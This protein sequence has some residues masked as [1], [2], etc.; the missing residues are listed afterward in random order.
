MEDTVWKYPH[1][2]EMTKNNVETVRWAFQL[3]RLLGREPMTPNEYRETV[4]RVKPRFDHAE[5]L[6]DID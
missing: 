3:A 1:S 2:D 4:L 6:K 5:T